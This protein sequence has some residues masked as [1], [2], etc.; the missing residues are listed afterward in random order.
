MIKYPKYIT[1]ILKITHLPLIVTLFHSFGI[2]LLIFTI[3]F[4][5]MSY[6]PNPKTKLWMTPPAP[7]KK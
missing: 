6:P 7:V 5:V 1:L 4:S 3:P 2:T